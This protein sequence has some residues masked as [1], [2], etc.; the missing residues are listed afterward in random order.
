[1][2]DYQDIS[3][4]AF[5]STAVEQWCLGFMDGVL[6]SEEVWFNIEDND[7]IDNLELAFGVVSLVADREQIKK[8]MEDDDYVKKIDEAQK[9][10]PQV[11]LKLD[12][13]SNSSLYD[14]LKIK[15]ELQ[16]KSIH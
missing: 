12:E 10:L 8:E 14:H 16:G 4:Q 13:M 3:T 6:I 1:M 15:P 2:P 5:G 7:A 11:I 9:F